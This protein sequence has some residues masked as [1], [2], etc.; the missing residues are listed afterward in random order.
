MQRLF[1]GLRKA[2]RLPRHE[3]EVQA[4]CDIGFASSRRADGPQ[5]LLGRLRF[6]QFAGTK[7][8]PAGVIFST[9]KVAGPLKT[10]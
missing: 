5:D 10:G 7:A 2:S 3:Y 9:Y 6:R 1:T 4:W 8:M